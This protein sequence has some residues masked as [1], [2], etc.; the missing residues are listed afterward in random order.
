MIKR[1]LRSTAGATS[2][3]YAFI[4]TLIAV[5]IVTALTSTGSRLKVVFTS[6]SSGFR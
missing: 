5:A 3:E 2:I 1:L 4:A 6:V